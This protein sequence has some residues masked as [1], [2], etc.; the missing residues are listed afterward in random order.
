MKRIF[1]VVLALIASLSLAGCGPKAES[2]PKPEEVFDEYIAALQAFD[3]EKSKEY[4]ADGV[5]GDLVL[6]LSS[7]SEEQEAVVPALKAWLGRMTVSNVQP[8]V[9]GDTATITFDISI[10]KLESVKA[11][12]EA[13]VKSQETINALVKQIRSEGLTSA[14][15]QQTRLRELL[16]ETTVNKLVEA[17]QDPAVEMETDTGKAELIKV[18]KSW[19][20]SSMSLDGD[21]GFNLGL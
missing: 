16:V 7:L 4:V 8:Q 21:F 6:D 12:A 15:A 10:P 14:E 19:K 18:D 1:P 11:K 3:F 2:G 5:D 17:I 20:V 13:A 9:D